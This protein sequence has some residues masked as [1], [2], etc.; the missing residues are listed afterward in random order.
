VR[1]TDDSQAPDPALLAQ[2][3]PHAQRGRRIMRGS[4]TCT[5]QA[6]ENAACR[7]FQPSYNVLSYVI[8]V[9]S[10]FDCP[11]TSAAPSPSQC[12][13]QRA[14]NT[15]PRWIPAVPQ[16]S[17]CASAHPLHCLTDSA[18]PLHHSPPTSGDQAAYTVWRSNHAAQQDMHSATQEDADFRG[19]WLT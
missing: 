12:H 13:C 19:K 6:R 17:C 1:C 8:R 14:P 10:W 3:R 11:R 16:P 2:R 18:Y 15:R 7:H 4:K 9:C 5:A